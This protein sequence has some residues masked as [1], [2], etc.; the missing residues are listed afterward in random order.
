VSENET[1][2]EY[3][4]L[5]SLVNEKD[6]EIAD[7]NKECDELQ[8]QIHTLTI[9]RDDLSKVALERLDEIE[10]LRCESVVMEYHCRGL[11]DEIKSNEA[12]LT[13]LKAGERELLEEYERFTFYRDSGQLVGTWEHYLNQYANRRIDDFLASREQKGEKGLPDHP[14]TRDEKDQDRFQE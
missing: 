9:D 6:A 14:S 4:R 5:N 1:F 12:E 11:I 10:R 8:S 13:R 2:L 3:D 7:A